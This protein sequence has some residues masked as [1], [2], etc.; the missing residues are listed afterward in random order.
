MGQSLIRQKLVDAGYRYDYLQ[1]R[2][3]IRDHGYTAVQFTLDPDARSASA[4]INKFYFYKG[5]PLLR[6]DQ[7]E[8]LARRFYRGMSVQ[9]WAYQHRPLARLRRKLKSGRDVAPGYVGLS[10][11]DYFARIQQMQVELL[12]LNGH[13]DTQLPRYTDDYITPDFPVRQEHFGEDLA[14]FL[15]AAGLPAYLPPMLNVSSYPEGYRVVGEDLYKVNSLELA[16]QKLAVKT[17]NLLT[18]E[19]RGLI[20]EIYD[21]DF[22]FFGYAR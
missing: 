19:T 1:A 22:E 4:F 21:R 17:D 18:D 9:N 20:G 2:H 14:R 13:G 7:L 3:L 10:F 15:Q 12:E 5:D 11:R 6:L 16:R 8:G